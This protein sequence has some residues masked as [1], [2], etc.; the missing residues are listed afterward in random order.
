MKGECNCGAI[1][2]H[3]KKSP[4]DVYMC[5]CSICC[6][7]TG[8]GGIAVVIV[9]N[10]HFQW[11]SGQDVLRHWRKPDHDW[12][13]YFCSVCGSAMPGENDDDRMYIPV[14]TLS[15]GVDSLRLSHHLFVD[16][17]AAWE[18]LSESAI[19]HKAGF[20]S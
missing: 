7:S 17:K 8:S 11:L 2:Y 9:E 1:R 3:L 20:E 18:P 6:K 14:G 5:H 15:D 4:S 12:H 16:S 19:Q 13:S 10:E